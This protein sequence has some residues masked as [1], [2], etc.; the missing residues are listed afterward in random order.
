MEDIPQYK[1]ILIGDSTVGKTSIINRFSENDFSK[2]HIATIGVDFCYAD[3]KVDGSPVRL[4][5]WDTAGQERFKS[6]AR[7]YYRG[8]QGVIVVYAIDNL[9]SFQNVRKW[10]AEIDNNLDTISDGSAESAPPVVKYIVGNKC[11]LADV[12]CVEEKRGKNEAETFEIKFM[13][14]SA[15]SSHNIEEL[16]VSIARDVKAVAQPM[17]KPLGADLEQPQPEQ[18]S[19]CC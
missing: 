19:G 13:E 16:F 18:K 2:T 7:S 15:K 10:L 9:G 1:I 11:D 6:I 14:T 3:V 4:Q 8:A 12:R 5:I 17:K